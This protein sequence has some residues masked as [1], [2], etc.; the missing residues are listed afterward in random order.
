MQSDLHKIIVSQQPLSADHIKVFT[1]QI[2][3]GTVQLF[4]LNTIALLF[5][6]CDGCLALNFPEQRQTGSSDRPWPRAMPWLS[7]QTGLISSGITWDSGGPC[8]WWSQ[9]HK[10]EATDS[11]LKAK[12]KD[13]KIVFEDP[14]GGGLVLKDSNTG[15]HRIKCFD[16]APNTLHIYSVIGNGQNS[17]LLP[18]K[19]FVQNMQWLVKSVSSSFSK[20]L[21]HEAKAKDSTCK[22]KDFKIVLEDEDLS[23][24]TPTLAP[25]Q[26]FK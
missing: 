3:R 4:T 5:L 21:S 15:K 23:L 25:A 19:S 18:L 10:A 16:E 20:D 22:T 8:Q 24:R 14:R 9:G 13:F 12:T 26:I 6:W 2:L 17:K 1:Y 7:R 11:T